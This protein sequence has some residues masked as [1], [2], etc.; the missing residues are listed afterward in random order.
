MKKDV[1]QQT[2]SAYTLIEISISLCIMGIMSLILFA[3]INTLQK[4]H[5]IQITKYREQIILKAL[6]AYINTHNCLPYPCKPAEQHIGIAQYV[7]DFSE[8]FSL[9]DIECVGVVPWKTLGISRESIY[10][11]Y[12]HPFTY[13]MNPVLGKLPEKNDHQPALI[14]HLQSMYGY[15]RD[16][17]ILPNDFYYRLNSNFEKSTLY[18]NKPLHAADFLKK[19]DDN[20]DRF[21]AT[22]IK[23]SIVKEKNKIY[24]QIKDNENYMINHA[25]IIYKH[26]YDN[27]IT[28]HYY[29][30]NQ[31]YTIH[32]QP[33]ENTFKLP[34]TIYNDCLTADCV[35]VVIIS[36]GTTGGHYDKEGK[37]TT[38]KHI[39]EA[40]QNATDTQLS[41]LN[42]DRYHIY[43]NSQQTAFDQ[44]ITYVTR[45]GFHLYGG[46]VLNNHYLLKI[47][48]LNFD[49]LKDAYYF[50]KFTPP[51]AP[52]YKITD[53][54]N[55]PFL[56][57]QLPNDTEHYEY[58]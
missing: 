5:K 4:S 26:Q 44:R 42:H 22:V 13:I 50:E 18:N 19:P 58:K 47:T 8:H 21:Q 25:D 38:V 11:G 35:G 30:R 9:T 39:H 56:P 24:M 33:G 34:L 40:I 29:D 48:D 23:E 1:S 15:R 54:D 10:D 31:E 12:G 46:P 14:N 45:F 20:V 57:V 43:L 2:M 37:R 41:P 17:R 27:F 7:P 36:H 49:L 32:N 55:K 53:E 52:L 16:I 6:G 28:L 51:F 3:T